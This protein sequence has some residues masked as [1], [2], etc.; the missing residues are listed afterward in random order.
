MSNELTPV[1]PLPVRPRQQALDLAGHVA[2]ETASQHVFADYLSR[3][4]ERTRRSQCN[5]LDS[6]S[7]FLTAAG[8]PH[9]P[10]GNS[11]QQDPAV[12]A[13]IT[14][15]LVDAFIR[16]LLAEGYATATIGRRLSTIKVYA[17]LAL[18]A[19]ALPASECTKIQTVR[20]WHGK[21]AKRIDARRREEEIPTRVG[22]KKAEPTRITQEQAQQLK[23]QP[24]T[25]QGRRDCLLVCLFLEHGLR[26]SEV[27]ILERAHFDAG[28]G[29]LRFYRPKVDI[30]QTHKLT[31]DTLRAFYAYVAAGDA[32]AEGSIWRRSKKDG[33]LSTQGLSKRAIARRIRRLGKEAG[34]WQLSPHDLR[35]YWATYW[36]GRTELFRLQEAGGWSS[37]EMPRRYTD[38]AHVANEGMA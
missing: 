22:D 2:N 15:G 11:L 35:H 33:S 5:D 13:G 25:P 6:F 4:A 36:A 19:G 8:V 10:D 18:R 31:A 16:W 3:K 21:E 24:N 17:K 1:S 34:V 37:L 26:V 27:A 30:E 29:I 28:A 20:A 12:W 7:A 32:P 14:W 38:R 23:R 9:P